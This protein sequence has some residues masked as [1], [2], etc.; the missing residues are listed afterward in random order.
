MPM[1]AIRA[2]P[3]TEVSTSGSTIH[4]VAATERKV[5]MHIAATQMYT[6]IRMV[7]SADLITSLVAASI[8]ALP[9]ASR[10]SRP[11]LL[12]SWANSLTALTARSR[13]S[14]L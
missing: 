4:R 3:S 10:N 9:A 13:V 6:R 8:P 5:I 11:S 2:L 7:S 14:A 1:K 12:F